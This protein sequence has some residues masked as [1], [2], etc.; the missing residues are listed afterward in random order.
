MKTS[1]LNISTKKL[2][3]L[4]VAFVLVVNIVILGKVFFNR[5]EV[6]TTLQ[7]S[8]RELQFPYNYGFKKEDSSKRLSIQWS[9]LNSNPVSLDYNELRWHL[10]RTLV[11]SPAHYSSFQFPSCDNDKR[12]LNKK[13]GWVLLE[14]N[15]QSYTDY[16]TKTEQYH[17]LIHSQ[18]PTSDSELAKKELNEK[19]EEADKLLQEA[20]NSITRLIA[21]DAAA[22]R[23]ALEKVMQARNISGKTKLLIVPTE[24]EVNYRYSCNHAKNKERDIFINELS[25]SSLYLPKHFAQE[26][27]FN[28]GKST[29]PFIAVVNYGRLYE[30]WIGS[31]KT[32]EKNCE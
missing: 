31:L 25:V 12:Q 29:S 30:P 14:F 32:C 11:L 2:A 21:I 8:E 22:T 23:S 24:V 4:A 16:V 5:S 28:N 9:A 18:E 1:P 19:R 20:K 17:S 13:S 7:L 26:L 10:D 15:G 6:I 27:T 3:W